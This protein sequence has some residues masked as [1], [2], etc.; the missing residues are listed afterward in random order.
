MRFAEHGGEGQG[1]NLVVEIVAD[2]HDPLFSMIS[3]RTTQAA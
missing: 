2:M 3:A 1:E